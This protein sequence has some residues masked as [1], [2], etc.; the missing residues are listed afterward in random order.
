MATLQPSSPRARVHA[1]CDDALGS[2]DAV[3][4]GRLVADGAIRPAELAEAARRRATLVADRLG[5]VA[6]HAP[7]PRR[8]PNPSSELDGVPTYVKDTTDIAGM[9]SNHGTAA[10]VARPARRD[11]A[12]AAQFLA[13]GMTV[14]GKSR[15]PEFGF[16]ASTEFEDEA[17]ARNPWDPASSAGGSSGGAAA[18]VAAG[19][20]PIAHAN[21]GGGSIRI[22]AA[23]AGLVGLKPTRGRHRDDQQARSLPIN[24]IGEGVVS[25]TVRDT[26]AFAHAMERSW[27]NP[28][29]PP[30]G[31]V[32]DPSSRRLRIGVLDRTLG[33]TPLDDTTRTALD[34]TAG[35]LASLGHRVVPVPAPVGDGFA[36]DFLDYWG[37][38]SLLVSIGGKAVFDRSF[39]PTRMDALSVGLREHARSRLVRLPMALRRLKRSGQRCG[40]LFD[41]H[42]VVLSPVVARRTPAL[43][44]L[45]PQVGYPQLIERLR[46]HVA[47]TPLQN[48]AG[49]PSITVPG[50]LDAGGLP[51]A[52]MLTAS[53]GDERTLLE[54]AFELEQARP[55][56]RIEG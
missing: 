19:V 17:P 5:A 51:T 8:R 13:T 40:R 6:H 15:M 52:T 1:F 48:V 29:L 54:L 24:L 53:W 11:G 33:D 41:R 25:R 56:P 32:T 46:A 26:A 47:F 37:L 43:G 10:L 42:E 16:N 39:D 18:L 4:L 7:R 9:P 30:I 3:A 44:H 12:F 35:L 38:L 34:A 28:S 49:L 20:V 23:A 36:E 22:P 31:R 21:D 14:L 2:R 45:S 27:R 50:D 55:F